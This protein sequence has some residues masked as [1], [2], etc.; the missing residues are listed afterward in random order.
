MAGHISGSAPLFERFTLGDS[1]TLRGWNKYEVAPAGGDS[2]FH[3]SGEYRY[4]GLAIF[5]DVGSVW[6]RDLEMHV[7]AASGFGLHIDKFFAT[8]AFPLNAIDVGGTF[9][10]GVRF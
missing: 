3:V 8:Y 5:T 1:S 6:D 7:R 9:M 2:M 10:I 4:R